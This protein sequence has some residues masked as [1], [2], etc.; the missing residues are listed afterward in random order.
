MSKLL[1]R[2][3]FREAVLARDHGKC[4]ITGKPADAV[5]HNGSI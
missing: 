5:H 1:T 3:E 2:D 4:V